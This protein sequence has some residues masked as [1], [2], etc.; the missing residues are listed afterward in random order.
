MKLLIL[1][2]LATITTLLASC[3]SANF[4]GGDPLDRA[5]D[6]TRSGEMMN[7]F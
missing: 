2:A 6:A 7:N 3:G 1:A 4:A 5:D